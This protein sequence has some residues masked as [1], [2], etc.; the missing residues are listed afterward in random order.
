MLTF[1][2]KAK[3]KQGQEISRCSMVLSIQNTAE[4][5]E[6]LAEYFTTRTKAQTTKTDSF[7]LKHEST[8]PDENGLH[9]KFCHRG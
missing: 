7:Q 6:N 3:A 1:F 4:I 2:F 8:N 9:N 5:L